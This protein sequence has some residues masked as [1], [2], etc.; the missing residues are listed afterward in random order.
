MM[1]PSGDPFVED[2]AA[3]VRR[4]RRHLRLSQERLARELDVSHKSVGKWERAESQP[5]YANLMRLIRLSG[6]APRP[7]EVP[8]VVRALA[9][10][11]GSRVSRFIPSRGVKTRR[12]DRSGPPDG[13]AE[14][15]PLRAAI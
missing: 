3:Y 10:T 5:S 7:L 11:N 13:L 8:A 14:V 12:P 4:V 1:N 6:L 9:T 2:S 15:I